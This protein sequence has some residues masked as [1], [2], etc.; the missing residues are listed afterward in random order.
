MIM[1]TKEEGDHQQALA[2]LKEDLEKKTP[3]RTRAIIM[4]NYCKFEVLV[5]TVMLMFW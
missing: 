5:E 2:L 1:T 4:I 3:M